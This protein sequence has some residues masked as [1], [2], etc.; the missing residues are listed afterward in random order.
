MNGAAAAAAADD[1]TDRSI[2]RVFVDNNFN[3]FK[4][5]L[6]SI[7]SQASELTQV[8]SSVSLFKLF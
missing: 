1:R 2:D 3:N 5:V 8:K 7:L 6:I 4:I